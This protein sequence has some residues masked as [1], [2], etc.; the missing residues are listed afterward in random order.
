[1]F[2]Y[3]VRRLMVGLVLLVVMSFVTF[4]LF[5]AA[6]IDPGRFACGKNCSPARVEQTNKALG[7][8]KPWAVQWKDFAIGIFQGRSYPD[9]ASLRKAAPELVS[10]CAAPCLGYS[11]VNL[12]NVTTELKDKI[13]V[14]GSVALAAFL[15][16]IVGGI[17]LGCLA[18]LTKGSFIDRGV[19]GTSLVFYAFPTFWIGSFL[20]QFVAIKWGIVEVPSYTSIADGGLWTWA[21]N[22]LLPGLTLALF[23]MAGYV[24]MTRA[25]VLESMTEDYL[26]TAQAKG[27]A[28]RRILLKHTLRAAL[29]PI[30]TM[31][32]LDLASVLGGAVIAEQVF[33]FNGLGKLAVD[34]TVTFDLP[35][36][37]GLVLL[38]AAFVILANIVVDVLY[39]VIDPRVRVG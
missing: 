15:M 34:S 37:V 27:L 20:I 19:V 26:R 30:V 1:V 29:T 22:L 25:F 38:L 11:V 6:P 14:S 10:E 24:R 16:W 33:N 7:F 39:A 8:D 4:F 17:A 31:A 36:V 23:Y 18:A 13:P 3:V 9:D 28:P 5:F 12:E 21:S 2:A 32:G 35:T